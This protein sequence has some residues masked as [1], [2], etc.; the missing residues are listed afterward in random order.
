MTSPGDR[1]HQGNRIAKPC[2]RIHCLVWLR[3]LRLLAT[4]ALASALQTPRARAQDTTHSPSTAPTPKTFSYADLLRLRTVQDVRISPDG[5]RIAFVVST[6]DAQKDSSA[7]SV[8][9]LRVGGSQP[10]ELAPA[11]SSSPLWSPDS[12]QIAFIT[13]GEHGGQTL[14]LASAGDP[15]S[16]RTF[17]VSSQPDS[18]IWSPDGRWIGMTLFVPDTGA[19]SF[20]QQAVN[21]AE[22]SLNKPAG[23]QWAPPVKLTEE[24]RYHADGSDELKPGHTH[25]FVLSTDTGDLRQVTSGPFD[26]R[27][28]SWL[29]DSTGL[30]FAADRR[31]SIPNHL[32]RPA[33]QK[34]SLGSNT[35][36]QLSHGAEY[37]QD[38]VASTDGK[39]I[40]YT[41]TDERHAYYSISSLY[42]MRP[43]GSD[44]HRLAPRLDRDVYGPR[45]SI[46]SHT[47]FASYEDHGLAR[48]GVFRLDGAMT[49]AA[50]GTDLSF[51]VSRS[52][53]IAY[54]GALADRPPE[55][56][57]Q[58]PGAKPTPLTSHNDFL[59]DRTFGRLLHLEVPSSLDHVLVEA[60]VLLP[61]GAEPGAKLPAMLDM[62]GGPFGSDDAGWSSAD[63]LYAAAGYAVIFVNYRGST[64]YGSSFS[65]P[66][67]SNFPGCAYDDLMSV[68]D[69][70]VQQGIADGNRLF[71]T[72]GSAGGELTTWIIGKTNRFRAA[73]A[74]KPVINQMSDSLAT[75]QYLAQ[76]VLVT[77][78]WDQEQRFWARSPLSLIGSVSTPT[79][80]ITGEKDNRTPL[81]ETLQYYDALQLRN[82]PSALMRVPDASHESLRSRPSQLAAETAATIA[83]FDHYDP[84]RKR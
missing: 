24:L 25:L 84:G 38:P 78:P 39:W 66:A 37:V 73:V 41:S 14:T 62:H 2:R 71:V 56:T 47:L 79:L 29:P 45:W 31:A 12:R 15:Q 40:A 75:D 81:T 60:W 28:P 43:D 46:D 68:V 7:E 42:V 36:V 21:Q 1:N 19:P 70:V 59:R 76:A 77:P 9:L 10:V 52:G 58:H 65:E 23:A 44:P 13:P 27:G 6:T 53:D 3:Y 74:Y 35:V 22:A 49:E 33:V 67:N 64:S 57:L 11:P 5:Q 69:T 17:P 50:S 48:V 4:F 16:R 51:S 61:P 26:D 54:A 32:R 20:L 72:G 55:V 8:W 80:L 83:W 30:L 18:L 63:Q 82:I 34:V